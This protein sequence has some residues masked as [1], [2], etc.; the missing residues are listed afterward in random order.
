MS[1]L[2]S[3]SLAPAVFLFILT[4]LIVVLAVTQQVILIRRMR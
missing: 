2:N 3:V 4:G 1:N